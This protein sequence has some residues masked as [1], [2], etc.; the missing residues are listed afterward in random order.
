MW[1]H[2]ATVIDSTV[3]LVLDNEDS[4]E[5]KKDKILKTLNESLFVSEIVGA[6]VT[7]KLF[8]SQADINYRLKVHIPFLD[9]GDLSSK[10]SHVYFIPSNKMWDYTILKEGWDEIR[11]SSRKSSENTTNG[12]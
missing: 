12:S 6:K 8:T 2:D 11:G 5:K 7:T 4:C 1:R 10:V 3:H 9:E